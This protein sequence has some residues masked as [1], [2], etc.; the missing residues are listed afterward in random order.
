MY[1]LIKQ[2]GTYSK[3]SGRLWQFY[4]DEP[5]INNNNNNIDFSDNNDN[6]ISFKFKQQITGQPG[7]CGTKDI[8]IM[9]QLKYLS[10]FWRTLELSLINLL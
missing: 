7:N 1:N 9:T 10:N 6:S 2:S 4:R 8:K 5:A 3:I